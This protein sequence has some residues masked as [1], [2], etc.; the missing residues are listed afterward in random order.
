[1][2]S[3]R[4]FCLRYPGAVQ[5]STRLYFT[6]TSPEDLV[7]PAL[8]SLHHHDLS[9]YLQYASRINLDPTSTVYTGTHYEYTV[10]SSL[11]RLG[12]SLKRIGGS[13]DS[14]TDLI[15]TWTLPSVPNPL[16][17]LVQCKAGKRDGALQTRELEGA[18]VGAP[19]GWREHGVLGLLVSQ[20]SATKAHREALNRSRW[21][22][23]YMF[24]KADGKILQMI[25]NRK[26]DQEGLKGV[27]VGVRYTGGDISEKELVLT[28]N[29]E[30]LSK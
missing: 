30:V 9:S 15:G 17:V 2:L 16:K 22:M 25:W 11:E 3:R 21:P 5:Q 29:G 20:K 7:C 4:L 19:Q 18:F 14:G 8:G 28:W 27:S 1:M 23:A 13:F 12:M 24:C 6:K 10:L 26:A